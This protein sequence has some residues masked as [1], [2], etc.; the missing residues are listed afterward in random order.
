MSY[1]HSR[2]HLIYK[3]KTWFYVIFC[4]HY[5]WNSKR[6]REIGEF[7][8]TANLTQI[9]LLIEKTW[10]KKIEWTD[11]PIA[12][13]LMRNRS[14]KQIFWSILLERRLVLGRQFL[15]LFGNT[16]N[17]WFQKKCS[18]INGCNGVEKSKRRKYYSTE[19]NVFFFFFI[20]LKWK[21]VIEIKWESKKVDVLNFPTTAKRNFK[22]DSTRFDWVGA[23]KS[24]IDVKK[25]DFFCLCVEMTRGYNSSVCA[26]T[27]VV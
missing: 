21:F 19:C 14:E 10:T 16:T 1:N 9:F 26:G 20:Q 27:I 22:N 17:R 23:I 7:H 5:R 18:K 3:K 12:K 24:Q 4:R 25:S 2:Y 15:I 8:R 11:I 13:R 6:E